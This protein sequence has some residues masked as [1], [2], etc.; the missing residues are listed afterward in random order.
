MY[1]WSKNFEFH[2]FILTL[3]DFEANIL[4]IMQIMFTLKGM[5]GLTFQIPPASQ[6]KILPIKIENP[7][8]ND[9]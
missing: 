9:K 4:Y 8:K 2:G 5:N 6:N 1:N 3:K 7:A